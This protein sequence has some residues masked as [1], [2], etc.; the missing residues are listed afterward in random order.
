MK[1]NVQRHLAVAFGESTMSRTQVQ[2]WYSRFKEGRA[3][4]N[5]DACPGRPSTLTTDENIKAVKKKNVHNRR[6]T[7][8]EVTDDIGISFRSCQAIFMAVLDMKRAATKIVPKLKNFE[9]KQ[10]RMDIAQDMLTTIKPNGSVQKNQD[11]KKHVK[12]VQ[13]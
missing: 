11:R 6:I 13:M 8:R 9:Q 4:V 5:D 7:I 12:L 3:D 10:H 1:L 2:L